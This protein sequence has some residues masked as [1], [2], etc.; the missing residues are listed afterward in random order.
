MRS[1]A[2]K[3]VRRGARAALVVLLALL[4]LISAPLESLATTFTCSKS[5]WSAVP[6]S[7]INLYT[8]KLGLPDSCTVSGGL[9]YFTGG[10]DDAE[11]YQVMY[12]SKSTSQSSYQAGVFFVN[13]CVTSATAISGTATLIWKEAGEDASGNVIDVQ[14]TIGNIETRS[15][16]G[17]ASAAPDEYVSILRVTEDGSVDI[18]NLLH[19]TAHS[20]YYPVAGLTCDVNISFFLTGTTT[21]ASGTHIFYVGDIDGASTYDSV[22]W[23]TEGITVSEEGFATGGDPDTAYLTETTQV[24]VSN[25]YQTY[26]SDG[27]NSTLGE[28]GD[29][30]FAAVFPVESSFSF[31]AEL[32]IS[33][34]RLFTSLSS[35]VS[36]SASDGGSIDGPASV[37]WKNDATYLITPDDGYQISSLVVDSVEVEEAVGQV[38]EFSYTLT[39]VSADTSIEASFE[40]VTYTLRYSTAK[41]QGAEAGTVYGSVESQ[42]WDVEDESSLVADGSSLYLFGY[43]FGYWWGDAGDVQ[44]EA[45][46]TIA[47]A[48][49][50]LV[51]ASGASGVQDLFGTDNIYTL[52]PGWEAVDTT[53]SMQQGVFYIS[54][55]AG[56]SALIDNLP[57]GVSYKIYELVSA[58]QIPAG[59][60]YEYAEGWYLVA[61]GSA[62]GAR[63]SADDTYGYEVSGTVQSLT[64]ALATFTN[65][66]EPS[67]GSD[68]SFTPSVLKTVDGSYAKSGAYCFTLT[69]TTEG[70]SFSETV[71]NSYGLVEFS[72]IEYE[73][74]GTYTYRIEEVVPDADDDA[75]D[76]TIEYDDSV[77]YVKVL[78][79]ETDDGL[80]VEYGYYLDASFESEVDGTP[81]FENT[82]KTGR[83]RIVKALENAELDDQV[84]TVTVVWGDG[85][86][87]ETATLDQ[88]NGWTWDS[89]E[90][91][92]GT[93]YVVY[94]YAADIPEGYRLESISNRLGSVVEDYTDESVV[95]TVS[96][97]YEAT[98]TFQLTAC[99]QLL[100][101]GTELAASRFSFQLVDLTEGSAQ[102]GQVV[103][104]A[105]NASGDDG[106][107]V[108][109]DALEVSA[110]GEYLYQISE[111]IPAAGE[112]GYDANITYDSTMFYARV[113]AVDNGD[114]TLDCSDVTYWTDAECTES[115]STSVPTFVNEKAPG[116]I[117]I[118]KTLVGVTAAAAS[119]EF[120]FEVLLLSATGE[121]LSG[122][123]PYTVT[124]SESGDTVRTAT[125][126]LDSDGA[127]TLTLLAGQMATIE[128]VPH[129]ASYEVSERTEGL[130]SAYVQLSP[131][132]TATGS[133]SA[134][135]T[136]KVAFTNSYSSYGTWA[137]EITK[138]LEGGID[139]EEGVFTFE[140]YD[141]N[142]TL[143]GQ[144]KNAYGSWEGSVASEDED[145]VDSRYEGSASG[146]VD[147]SGS[148]DPIEYTQDDDQKTFTYTI[149]ETRLADDDYEAATEEIVVTVYVEDDGEGTMVATA[150]YSSDGIFTNI[151]NRWV[152]LPTT[153][154]AGVAAGAA[155]GATLIAGA[156]WRIARRRR[157]R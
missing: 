88:S 45:G 141:E 97:A 33:Y 116:S 41:S 57:A 35:T 132:G 117:S 86:A 71:A 19:S 140:L 99:K 4:C 32:S 12:A 65:H 49:D 91:A 125:M 59:Y 75:F 106:G 28:D 89:S 87:S 120:T 101:E 53:V 96:N 69:E 9:K 135:R 94:E 136:S 85:S 114:G 15:T 39:E 109:F 90:H 131:S 126:E 123:Y 129:G 61:A 77:F 144:A 128:E 74:A 68:A 155:V 79:E 56:E 21:L 134:G 78:V 133:V 148:M 100:P 76:S 73:E 143:L 2:A 3:R 7:T 149:V 150:S 81:T 17:A 44:V 48:V 60:E 110:A 111:R 145:D 127:G 105:V 156:I 70:A 10:S 23:Y 119:Q 113:A 72:T 146:T 51:E 27:N 142:G 95:V 8:E 1:K 104:T 5:G 24:C 122:S 103:D 138:L 54:L 50:A 47:S 58:E 43:T 34:L 118:S 130:P 11:T 151:Y 67:T 121:P 154:K 153:G 31:S 107:T 108:S 29:D 137:P 18:C 157:G 30:D 13:P 102:Y 14:L 112:T 40:P 52:Y 83:I 92:V 115:I 139:L 38:G 147:F 25:A 42:T 98:G 124:E 26:E 66:T 22:T 37:W 6:A 82:T 80:A 62:N 63:V 84:F 20:D 46:Q 152:D 36:T 64:T 93:G 16:P 55:R